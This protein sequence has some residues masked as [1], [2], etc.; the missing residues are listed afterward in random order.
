MKK[1]LGVLAAF[2]CAFACCLAL[3]GCG[4]EDTAQAKEFIGTWNLESVT[5]E[6]SEL[7]VTASDVA[8]MRSFGN[9]ASLTLNADGTANFTL[10][11][12]DTEC[13]WSVKDSTSALLMIDG[14]KVDLTIDEEGI[15]KMSQGGEEAIL[16]T[17]YD[18][19]AEKEAVQAAE[20]GQYADDA[21]SSDADQQVADA[22]TTTDDQ[23]G[24]STDASSESVDSTQEDGSSS[25]ESS[26]TTDST[27]T[28]G[29]AS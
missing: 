22:S 27:A 5:A 6:S 21:G 11:E 26:A 20:G 19:E 16:F 10:F 15:L 8:L 25:G 24:T 13:E 29:D 23:A 18:P 4:G 2:A 17:K 3:V 14:Q 7:K 12:I 1:L 28:T 9:T